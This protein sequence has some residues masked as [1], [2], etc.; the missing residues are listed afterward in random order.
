MRLLLLLPLVLL[1][2]G[3]RTNE[4]PEAQVDDL[5]IATQLKSKLAADVG[6]SSVTNISVN[7]T[8]GVVTLSGQVDT[9]QAKAKAGAL[10]GAV[11]KVVRVVNNL[12]VVSRKVSLKCCGQSLS[13]C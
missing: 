7:S 11:P 4:S 2:L 6:L 13:Y 1:L 5:K 12:Q 8:N 10:A 9:E 3:C